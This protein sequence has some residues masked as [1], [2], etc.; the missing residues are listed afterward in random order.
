MVLSEGTPDNPKDSGNSIRR[1][2]HLSLDTLKKWIRTKIST[3]ACTS[4]CL[5]NENTTDI[6]E[7]L[8]QIEEPNIQILVESFL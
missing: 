3:N 5:R 6:Y 8:A 1:A 4:L 7:T 2:W